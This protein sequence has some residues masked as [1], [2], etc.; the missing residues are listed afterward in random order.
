MERNLTI[1][2]ISFK[3]FDDFLSL[4]DKLAEY[5]KLEPPDENAKARLKEDGLG[6]NPKYYA[7]LGKLGEKAIGYLIFFMTYSSFLAKPT[8]YLEDIFILEEHRRRGFGEQLFKFCINQAK[9][10]G[11]GRIEFCV[12]DWNEHAIQFYD[13]NKAKRLNW[14]FYRLNEEQIENY[15]IG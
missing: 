8:L 7:Y 12:L 6:N 1:E 3:N 10:R 2:K 13:K 15:S 4:I 9:A 5:E 11:C 14:I